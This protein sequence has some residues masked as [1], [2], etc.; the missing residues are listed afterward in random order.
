MEILLKQNLENGLFRV[1]RQTTKT[2]LRVIESIRQ[3]KAEGLSFKA[4]TQCLESNE[5]A[6]QDYREKWHP[7]MV[8]RIL[9]E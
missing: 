1:G 4:I 9:N 3:M 5:D 6:K 7:E 2:E 8:K